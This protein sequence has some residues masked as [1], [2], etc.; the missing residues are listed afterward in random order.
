MPMTAASPYRI[1]LI[2]PNTSTATTAQMLAIARQSLP[3]QASL[4][5]L[6]A[7]HG[8]ALIS[9]PQALEQAAQMILDYGREV[10]EQGFDSLIIAGFGDPGLQA[11][12]GAIALPVTG[13]AE[14]GI[15]EAACAGRRFSIVTVTPELDASLLESAQRYGHG[16][17]LASIRYT[18]GELDQVMADPLRLELALT[19]AC[20]LAMDHDGAQAIVI[21]G[22]PLAS[23]ARAIARRLPIPIIDPV[24][25]A[26][27][28]ACARADRR[29]DR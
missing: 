2:N 23:A 17:A 14:A 19:R 8:P 22:G 29:L 28:L 15:G 24:G 5:G 9:S 4:S 3:P 11:L 10:A 12:R 1:A 6:T 21:G 25:A 20:Q 16:H 27:R 26:V 13:L 18:D 7:P